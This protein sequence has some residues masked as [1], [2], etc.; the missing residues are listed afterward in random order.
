M[1]YQWILFDADNTLFDFDRA[2][3]EALQHTLEA[4]DH[5]F[6]TSQLAT[7]E[8]INTSYWQA[9]ERGEIT[10]DLLRVQRF[11]DLLQE[12]EL[13]STPADVFAADYEHN[14]SLGTHLL[15]GAQEILEA[16]KPHVEM[17]L[18]TNGLLDVQRPRLT[19]STIH[20]YFRETL[21][22]EEVGAAKPDPKIF[23]IAFERMGNPSRSEVL[24]VG[25]SLSSDI[26]GGSDFGIDT[27]WFNPGRKAR[28]REV[29]ITFEITELRELEAICVPK[30]SHSEQA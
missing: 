9:F 30:Q 21:I 4:Y 13:T 23:E 6:D 16:L 29:A 5:P 11:E 1:H 12:L 20:S 19:R 8:R 22:S 10:Q 26:Q 14:L 17:A 3:T 2:A 27:C 25:D 24:I 28:D 15:E 7:Y 18:I